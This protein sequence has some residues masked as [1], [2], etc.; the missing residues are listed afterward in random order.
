MR[1]YFELVCYPL[2]SVFVGVS[3]SNYFLCSHSSD[4]DHLNFYSGKYN[5]ISVVIKENNFTFLF[6]K[7][8]KNL[9]KNFVDKNKLY[10]TY[11]YAIIGFFLTYDE[12]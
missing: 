2:C 12:I 5:I 4:T 1:Q 3:I 9:S 10:G 6:C 11:Y 7:D 8:S